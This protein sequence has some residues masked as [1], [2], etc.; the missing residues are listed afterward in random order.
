[1]TDVEAHGDYFLHLQNATHYHV[2]HI[3]TISMIHV[4]HMLM[5]GPDCVKIHVSVLKLCVTWKLCFHLLRREEKR[6]CDSIRLKGYNMAFP[7]LSLHPSTCLP[8]YLSVSL[9]PLLC[10]LESNLCLNGHLLY[11]ASTPPLFTTVPHTLPLR[12]PLNQALHMPDPHLLSPPPP[13]S[14]TPFFSPHL[15]L[16]LWLLLCC[17]CC[18]CPT[19]PSAT[20]QQRVKEGGRGRKEWWKRVS[21]KRKTWGKKRLRGKAE[22]RGSER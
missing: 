16:T 10:L 21:E 1:M 8:S 13:L 18:C 11:P 7:C 6:S 9:S 5:M 12:G 3:Y 2:Y 15:L 17:C 4:S 20:R 22:K 14:T 19:L